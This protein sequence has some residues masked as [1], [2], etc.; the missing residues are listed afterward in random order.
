MS[1]APLRRGYWG[2]GRRAWRPV[3]AGAA[4]ATALVLVS[5]CGLVGG[6]TTISADV[7]NQMTVTSPDFGHGLSGSAFSCHGSGQHPVIY[8][9]GAPRGTQSFALV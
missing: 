4:A 6:A 3:R 1:R 8:W 2:A 9:S 5:G 7:P